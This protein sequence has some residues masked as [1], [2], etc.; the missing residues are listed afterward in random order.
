MRV[1]VWVLSS[2]ELPQLCSNFAQLCF[3]FQEFLWDKKK[4]IVSLQ[5]KDGA[6]A[7]VEPCFQTVSVIEE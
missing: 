5:V 4:E 3:N 2:A 6:R 7:D 1:C